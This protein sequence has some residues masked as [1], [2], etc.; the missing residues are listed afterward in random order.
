MICE[1]IFCRKNIKSDI[2][3]M[4]N[5]GN[6]YCSDWCKLF[7]NTFFDFKCSRQDEE[8]NNTIAKNNKYLLRMP[9]V[10]VYH[11]IPN[12]LFDIPKNDSTNKELFQIAINMVENERD[13]I[14][15]KENYSK[16]K[17]NKE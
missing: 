17:E 1:L 9:T 13:K 6:F 12:E 15:K 5:K 2:K 16:W 14:L 8:Y 11:S 3:I 7:D 10:K 4:D